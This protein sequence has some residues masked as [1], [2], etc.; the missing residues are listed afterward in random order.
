MA[1]VR[2]GK[3]R[4]GDGGLPAIGGGNTTSKLGLNASKLKVAVPGTAPPKEHSWEA[5][6]GV[7]MQ[8]AVPG[9]SSPPHLS[10]LSLWL[11]IPLTSVL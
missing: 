5:V 6:L 2:R 4:A 9:E 3:E 1:N 8:Q 7:P 11:V 10:S